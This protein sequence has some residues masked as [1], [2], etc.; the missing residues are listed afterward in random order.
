MLSGGLP[1]YQSWGDCSN[2]FPF[3]PYGKLDD[4]LWAFPDLVV[5]LGNL[6]SD[7]VVRR[8]NNKDPVTVKYLVVASDGEADFSIG[9]NLQF[10]NLEVLRESGLAPRKAIFIERGHLWIYQWIQYWR[11]LAGDMYRRSVVTERMQ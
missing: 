3:W 1:T 5:L 9:K 10:A 11:Q 7:Y 2:L 4:A 6:P 8:V